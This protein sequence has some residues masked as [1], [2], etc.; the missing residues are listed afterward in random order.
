M[1]PRFYKSR[2]HGLFKKKLTEKLEDEVNQEKR[3][4]TSEYSEYSGSKEKLKEEILKLEK[5]KE[6]IKEEFF[7]EEVINEIIKSI[8]IRPLDLLSVIENSYKYREYIQD[9][10]NDDVEKIKGCIKT[11]EKYYEFLKELYEI[12]KDGSYTNNILSYNNFKNEL[13]DIDRFFETIILSKHI[14]SFNNKTF[15]V[16]FHSQHM[17][18]AFEKIYKN[19]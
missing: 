4:L 8:G 14:V 11:N 17:K 7:K 19:Q 10:I 18:L 12:K 3:L 1:D 15:E 16:R 13:G 2:S 6:K 9:L 5:S